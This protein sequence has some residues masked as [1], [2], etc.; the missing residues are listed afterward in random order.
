[1][2]SAQILVPPPDWDDYERPTIPGSPA[3][4]RHSLPRRIAYVLVAL[5]VGITGALG[6]ALVTVNLASIQ[7]ELALTPMQGAWLPAAYATFNITANLLV[8]KF[9]QQYG[10]RLFAEIGLAAYA[11]L[12]LLH[13]FVDGFATAVLVRAASGLAAAAA[14]TMC[15]LYMLQSVPKQRMGQAVVIGVGVPQAA[16]PIAWL[17]SPRLLDLGNW[18]TLYLFE[19]GLALC[20]FAAV[21]ALKLPAGLHIRVLDRRDLLTFALV[22]PAVGLLIG[23]LSQGLNAWW[24]DTPWIGWA[25][26]GAIVLSGLATWYE[27][28][29]DQPLLRI[30]WLLGLS[31]LRFVLGVLTMRFLLSEQSYAAVGLMRSLGM[32]PD[33]M[34]A[35]FWVILA[36]ML[37]GIAISVLT[38]GPKALPWQIAL[39]ILLIA[40]T[41][42]LDHQSTSLSRP[43]DFFASQFMLAVA[44]TLFL[45]PML[46]IGVMQALRHGVDHL[47]TFIVLFSICQSLGGLLGTSL[48]GTLQAQRTQAHALAIG[49][50]VDATRPASG[51]RLDQQRQLYGRVIADPMRNAAQGTAQLAQTVRR[52]ASVRAYN[53]VFALVG[54]LGLIFLCWSLYHSLAMLRQ[55]RG[56]AA[57]P[58]TAA[59]VG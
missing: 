49:S 6:N 27:L 8:F 54:G 59:A 50:H 17:L 4:L 5:L 56:A 28:R 37:C 22:V 42:F 45:G 32:G 10:A 53:D 1:M 19:A 36:G 35:L 2:T 38:F 39:S 47:I 26:I 20:S 57:A 46:M 29:R 13:L 25:L 12:A 18:Q 58:N 34:Q 33:Q 21:V 15:V 11:L 31:T 3:T 52:E 30:D 51:Q 40:A 7:G 48:L 14:S 24:F 23:V 9:R 43:H 16:I 41:G 44:T 55:A